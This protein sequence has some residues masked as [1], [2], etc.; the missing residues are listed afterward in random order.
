MDEINMAEEQRRI[1][2]QSVFAKLAKGFSMNARV[3]P[4]AEVMQTIKLEAPRQGEAS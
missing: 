2:W 4:P 3:P 1:Y